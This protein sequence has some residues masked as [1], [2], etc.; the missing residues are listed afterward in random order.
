M[1]NL[2]RLCFAA[3]R[4]AWPL[5]LIVTGVLSLGIW[6]GYLGA[7]SLQA[8]Q[9]A[10][11]HS[12]LATFL[13]Q[14]AE[15]NPDRAQM[16]RNALYNNLLTGAIMYIMGLTVISLP[17]LLA[18]IFIRGFVLGFTVGFLAAQYKI[19]GVLVLL[20]S[21]LPH[22]IFF[23]PALIIGGTASMSFSLLLIKRFFNSHTPVWPGLISYT[24]LMAGVMA[25]FLLAALTEAYVTPELTRFSA[26]LL[27]G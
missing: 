27:A 24:L 10:E 17:L 3:F 5:Y 21:V 7:N 19:Q 12:Y 8:A 11:L 20:V 4:Q 18:F 6:A 16:A 14:L 2:R 26:V 23:V 1:I 15:I 13:A 9:S 22:N 25:V